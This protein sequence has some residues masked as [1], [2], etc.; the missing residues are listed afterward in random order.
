M[1]SLK[2][3]FIEPKKIAFWIKW[4][5]IATP[6]P[7]EAN[8]PVR[9]RDLAIS[10]KLV[11]TV[12]TASKRPTTTDPKKQNVKSY[13]IHPLRNPRASTTQFEHFGRRQIAS[14]AMQ[15]ASEYAFP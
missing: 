9:Q 12:A 1:R 4:V 2:A 8:P 6:T 15:I 14:P 5:P 11:F 7:R 3:V 13:P 10:R